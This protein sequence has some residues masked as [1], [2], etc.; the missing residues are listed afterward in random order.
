MVLRLKTTN[1]LP[2]RQ[3][4]II[5]DFRGDDWEFL[6]VTNGPISYAK[7]VVRGINDSGLDG[8]I[9]EFFPSVFPDHFL[10]KDDAPSQQADL[11]R[12][13]DDALHAL[14]RDQPEH[15]LC[16]AA[17]RELERRDREADSPKPEDTPCL[18]EPW[19]HT[20]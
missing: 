15:P 7:V 4:D 14:V 11:W 10:I 3:G 9:R 1:G 20:R 18:P 19:W 2:L 13:S 5:S 17:E 8:G 6:Y 16:N 12:M